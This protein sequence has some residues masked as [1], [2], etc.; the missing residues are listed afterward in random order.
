MPYKEIN[1][2]LTEDHKMLKEAVRDFAIKVL[3]PASLELDK[4]SASE[5]IKKDS[6]FFDTMKK[7]YELDYHTALIPE[8]MGGSGM[9][10]LSQHIFWEEMGYGSSGFA[11]AL[12]VAGFAPMAVAMLG[13]DEKL[14]ENFV[15]PYVNCTDA[16]ELSCWA[17]TEPNHGSD[18]LS[19]GTERFRNPNVSQQV[20]AVREG[21]KWVVNGQ[22]SAW[23]SCGPVA[24]NAVLFLGIDSSKGMAGGGVALIDLNQSGV[25]RGTPL[26]KIGQRELPQGEL[27]FDNAVVPEENMVVLPEG[28]EHV[29][30]EVL[31]H[32]NGAIM[33]CV[34]TGVAQ[35]AYD[36]ALQHCTERVVGGK[37]LGEH[38]FTQ[39]RLFDMFM[40]IET[41]R[42]YSRTAM[43]YNL[44]SG[45]PDLK[46]A[47]AA[48]VYCTNVACEVADEAVQLFGGYGL[49][50]EYPIE[51]IFR[52]ARVSRIE[53]G[54]NC[55]LSLVAGDLIAQEAM[56]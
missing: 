40:K 34:F 32:A 42:A 36:L 13:G 54:A 10:P 37:L 11:I 53:D 35:S 22:K 15:K 23:V 24:S 12:A 26:E 38:Q 50:K 55:N 44:T 16:S 56:S 14:V 17:I 52:D 28:Y 3:R 33:A 4:L 8:E 25:T 31:T 18:N 5:V 19:V 39:K 2:T 7:I 1:L 46:Y 43:L 47:I 51:K 21:N 20:K 48:K 6:L 29:L 41:A 9:G 45:T 49:S 30:R 27:F